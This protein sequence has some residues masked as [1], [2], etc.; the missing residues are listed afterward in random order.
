MLKKTF[1]GSILTVPLVICIASSAYAQSEPNIHIGSIEVHPSAS[2]KQTY[3]TNVF[4][5][6][7]SDEH[8]DSITDISLGIEA[9]MPLVPAREKDF[10][11]SASYQAN[12]IEYWKQ[13][14]CDRVDHLLKGSLNCSFANDIKL[15]INENY[16]KTADPPNSEI[17]S[18]D[19]R[20]KNT[21][22]PV[23]SY[24]REK[25]RVEGGYKTIRDS[26]KELEKLSKVDRVLTAKC[27]YQIFPKTSVL[28]EYDLG[29]IKYDNNTASSNSKYHNVNIGLVGK[30][31]P[32]TTGNLKLG[33]K[34]SDYD[35][36]D[37]NDFSGFT[38]FANME[39]DAT[40]R[41]KATLYA[42]R[43]NQES[44]YTSNNF[45]VLNK[46]GVDVSHKLKERL[47]L[48]AGCFL[49]SNRY[50]IK[51]TESSVYAKRRDSLWGVD[52]GLAYEVKSWLSLNADY[53]FKK[54]S[55]EFATFDYKDHK[56]LAELSIKY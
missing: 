10:N 11:L 56:I 30:F 15:S 4:L 47:M 41:T 16:K 52:A 42:Q 25:I 34:S 22:N 2:V 39:Y 7:K 9:E 19:K 53:K 12:I 40:V 17:T 23:I 44:T 29:R 35:E 21:F 36:N 26:Y 31:W 49:Q 46:I 24:V 55:S 18:L 38:V 27:F 8:R 14:Q 54:R 37:D 33:Y 3:D 48:D 5:E 32:K 28:V 43:S 1:L 50:P 6:S 20:S 51:T 13:D 45:F